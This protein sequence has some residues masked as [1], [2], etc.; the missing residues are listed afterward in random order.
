MNL[1]LS[2]GRGRAAGPAGP[3]FKPRYYYTV[4]LPRER[5]LRRVRVYEGEDGRMYRVRTVK[6]PVRNKPKWGRSGGDHEGSL[7][8]EHAQDLT[9]LV[10]PLALHTDPLLGA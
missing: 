2:T 6:G 7:Q 1:R 4:H 9:A 10:Q 3:A 5:K 8:L